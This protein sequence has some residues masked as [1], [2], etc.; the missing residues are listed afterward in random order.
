M[1]VKMGAMN[2]YALYRM[3]VYRI[4]KQVRCPTKLDSETDGL[5]FEGC[6]ASN[7]KAFTLLF[8]TLS[9]KVKQMLHHPAPIEAKFTYQSRQPSGVREPG[10]E[11]P[12]R[13]MLAGP[14]THTHTHRE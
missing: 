8:V 5:P 14:H 4:D 13:R 7:F 9:S 1:K 2:K 3:Y 10:N 12:K 11:S 6:G